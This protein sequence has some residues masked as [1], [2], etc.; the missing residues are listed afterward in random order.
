MIKIHKQIVKRS[1]KN[2]NAQLS[3]TY[4]ELSPLFLP[5]QKVSDCSLNNLCFGGVMGL[6]PKEQLN[7]RKK[8]T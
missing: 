8:I 3:K 1:F 7:W 5:I 2:I 4:Q 6:S